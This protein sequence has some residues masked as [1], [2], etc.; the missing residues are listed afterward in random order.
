MIIGKNKSVLD[1]TD[2]SLAKSKDNKTLEILNKD[3]LSKNTTATILIWSR[4]PENTTSLD[5][6]D[7]VSLYIDSVRINDIV[8]DRM[9]DDS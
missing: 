7:V 9:A 1:D 8:R 5:N 4:I 2:F 3:Y 6:I